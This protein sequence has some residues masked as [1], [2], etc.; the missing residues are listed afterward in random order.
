PLGPREALQVRVHDRPAQA[1]GL[2]AE[3]RLQHDLGARVGAQV[4]AVV[5]LHADDDLAAAAI[6]GD[7][8]H[9]SRLD[10]GDDDVG[11]TTHAGGVVE[12]AL[13]LVPLLEQ[14]E[15]ADH[16]GAADEKPDGQYGHEPH[17]VGVAVAERLHRAP[18]NSWRMAWVPD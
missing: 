16:E 14:V 8:R 9:P 15:D 7:A 6:G 5:H 18:P 4:H 13:D 11:A 12:H 10:A 2:G 3:Q 1:D 17:G